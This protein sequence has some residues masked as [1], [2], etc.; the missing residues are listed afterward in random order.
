MTMSNEVTIAPTA[1]SILIDGERINPE[2]VENQ[3]ALTLVKN[4]VSELNTETIEG[5][6]LPN[7][8]IMHLRS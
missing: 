1:G 3:L 7:R 6:G 8:I 2:T 5:G 4:A